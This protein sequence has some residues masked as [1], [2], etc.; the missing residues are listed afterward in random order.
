MLGF[1]F[2]GP[3][4]ARAI[5]PQWMEFQVLQLKI[6]GYFAAILLQLII[7]VRPVFS[8]VSHLGICFDLLIDSR[9]SIFA[10]FWFFLLGALQFVIRFVGR[11]YLD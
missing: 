6:A 1:L 8:V 11:G 9:G 4:S 2:A 7:H 3:W 10:C 5:S